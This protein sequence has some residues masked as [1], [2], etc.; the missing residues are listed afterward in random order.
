MPV[1]FPISPALNET[2]TFASNTWKWDGFTWKLQRSPVAGPAGP[3]GPTGAQ[4]ATGASATIAV[5][6]T[7]TGAEASSASVT[8][9]GTSSA[10]TLNFTIPRGASGGITLSVTN[11]GLSSYTINGASNPTLSFIRGHRYVINVNATGHPFWIQTVSGAYSA[12]N[13]YNTGVT[14]NGTASGTIIFEVPFDAPQLYYV[15]QNHPVMAGSI[16][17][18]NLGPQGVPGTNGTNGAQ[19]VPG[20]ASPSSTLSSSQTITLSSS[21]VNQ[22]IATSFSGGSFLL[23]S[24]QAGIADGASW[25]LMR[26]AVSPTSIQLNGRTAFYTAGL[27]LRAQY[28]VAT[29]IY[30]TGLGGY[31]IFGDLV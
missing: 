14:N 2:Y 7:T 9:S 1:N 30:S 13:V 22:M 15:C 16:T 31:V 20:P 23:P 26:T 21:N 4:G 10:A 19:G 24:S 18:S 12:G 28:S 8:N 25:T 17:V 11:S 6:T 5:G 27:N 29:V 3:A